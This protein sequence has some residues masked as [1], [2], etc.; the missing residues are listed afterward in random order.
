MKTIKRFI[1]EEVILPRLQNKEVLVIYDPARLYRELCNE[2]ASD[3]IL[4]VDATESSILSRE[5]AS[6]GLS[7]LGK[8]GNQKTMLVYIPA[9][10]PLTEEAKQQDPFAIYGA[11][12]G[13]FPQ[14][15][16]DEYL[17]ICLKAKPDYATEI[18]KVFQENLNPAFEVIDAIGKGPGWPHLQACLE[19]E[20]AR[21]IINALLAPEPKHLERLK[22][23]DAWVSEAR[24]LFESALGLKLLTKGKT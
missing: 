19:R 15:D 7:E 1:Q 23:S 9:T 4:V 24:G 16:G 8:V 11:I 18:R 6:K 12:G 13:I 21:E 5:A 20:S 2:L 10:P 17:S 14:G 3:N 22:A